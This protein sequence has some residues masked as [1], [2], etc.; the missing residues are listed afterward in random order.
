MRTIYKY[1]LQFEEIQ[2]IEMPKNASI[3]CIQTDKKNNAPHIWALVE[4]EN[5]I[6]E[7]QFKLYGTGAKINNTK[8][9]IYIGTFQYQNGSFVGHV[10]EVFKKEN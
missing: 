8:T 5:E 7:R 6:E 1:R 10:F 9:E 2:S 3:L 4:T